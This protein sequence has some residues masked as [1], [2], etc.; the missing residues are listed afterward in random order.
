MHSE[1]CIEH[2]DR[3]LSGDGGEVEL[4]EVVFYESGCVAD[5]VGRERGE[6]G[7][8]ENHFGSVFGDVFMVLGDDT[9]CGFSGE[10]FAEEVPDGV[11]L[12]EPDAHPYHRNDGRQEEILQEDSRDDDDDRGRDEKI[13]PEG[14]E[15]EDDSDFHGGIPI[16]REEECLEIEPDHI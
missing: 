7:P 11:C 15:R 12:Y 6:H 14:I 8:E 3:E 16:Q 1:E 10:V 13:I 5:D 9:E 4:Q 2:D